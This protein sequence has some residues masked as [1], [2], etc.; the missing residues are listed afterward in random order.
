MIL[1]KLKLWTISLANRR[2]APHWLGFVAF[3]E[4]SVFPIPIDVLYIPMLLIHPKRVYRYAFL[5]TLC[6]VLGGIAGWFIGHFAYDTLA[7]PILEFYGK[8]ESFESLKNTATL[9]LL[10]I[11]LI[12]SGFLHLPPIKIMTILAGVMSVRLE[13]FI[14]ICIFSR[15][16]RFYFLAWLIKHFGQKAMN[17]LAQHFKWIV[18]TGCVSLLFI[19]GIFMAFLNKQLL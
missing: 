16:A 12:T 1:N 19:Y 15:G 2:T 14:L 18:L 7:K 10:I 3:I 5:A 6:S 8:I 13:L 4:S 11:L 9:Q 17:F